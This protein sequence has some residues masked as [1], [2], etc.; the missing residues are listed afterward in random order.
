MPLRDSCNY[1]VVTDHNTY[2]HAMFNMLF[3]EGGGQAGGG[4]E[5]DSKRYGA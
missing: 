1:S 2:Q 4:G 3:K 5:W